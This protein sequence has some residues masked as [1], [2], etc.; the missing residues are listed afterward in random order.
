MKFARQMFAAVALAACVCAPLGVAQAEAPAPYN[1]AVVPFAG[2]GFV[3]GF[4]YH[5]K[6]P[7]ILY[8][9]TDVGGAYRFDYRNQVWLPLF[10]G[11]ER[12]DG[13]LM[14]V[15]SLALDP[16]DPEKVYAACGE[17]LGEW[18]RKGAILRSSDRGKTWQKS[19]LPI[20]VGG[21]ADGRGTGER[22]AVDPANGAN[23]YYGSNRDGLWKS[24]DGG[25]SFSKTSSPTMSISLVSINPHDGAI[26]LGS[27]D[28]KGAL[29]VSTDDGKTFVSA[30]GAPQMIPQRLAFAPDGAIYVTF[31]RGDGE[32]EVNPSNVALGS[33]WKREPGGGWHEITPEKPRVDWK[34]G[35][36]G[37]DV[38]PDGVVAV[39]TIDRWYPGDEVF[40][41]HD[42]G[43]SW[44]GLHDKSSRDLEAYPWTKDM[45]GNKES[46][47]GWISD[48]KINPF[49][50]NEMIYT[51]PWVTGNLSD[52]GTG[53]PVNFAFITENLEEAAVTQLV[54][55]LKGAKVMASMLD[56]SGAAW[57][58]TSMPPD[59][60][61][62]GPNKESNRSVDYAGQNPSV[63]VR[64][65]D[66]GPA[67]GYYSQDAGLSWAH[68]PGTIFDAPKWKTGWHT[69][70]VIAISAGAGAMLWTPEK[71]VPSYSK[72]KGKSWI[73][74]TGWPTTRDHNLYPISDKQI[75]GVFYVYD[76]VAGTVLI[77]VDGGASFK[78]IVEGMPKIAPWEMA[79][80]AVVPTRMRDLWLPYPG[81]LIHSPSAGK[82]AAQVADV[83][84]AWAIGFG[85]PL[86]AGGYPAVYLDGKIKGVGGIWRSDDEGKSWIRLNDAAHSF[87]PIGAITGDM[88]EPGTVYIAAGRGGVMV[89]KPAAQ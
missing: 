28:A 69:G 10:D 32:G 18:A 82:P 15:L 8:A 40:I 71:S 55:P 46:M 86:K 33:V 23:L 83:T 61:L 12:E 70:G 51:G 74:T 57:F 78:T 19:E 62:F 27:A 3:D 36:S 7:G 64:A 43:K 4:V 77:S 37:I 11:L 49:N 13:Q 60:G 50:K 88:R 76:P 24:V 65:S 54:S 85:A 87:E 42:S 84:A 6:K 9:R 72:D 1:W 75:E 17:Y 22:L 63:M 2:G 31:G 66:T 79:K 14:G 41:S 45:F 58:D 26:Y 80:L 81:G 48:L 16:S 20:R 68:L 29:L 25:V 44:T 30:T 56:V 53:K 34:W 59:E 38:G 39:S 21:N 73:E 47:S 5:P 89:G 35:Y 67:Y 52:A